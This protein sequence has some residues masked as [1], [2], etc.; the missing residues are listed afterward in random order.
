MER[1]QI[2]N[3][4]CGTSC[5]PEEHAVC[6]N[7][8]YAKCSAAVECFIKTLSDQQVAYVTA[9]ISEDIYLKAC[10]G[11]GKTEVIGIKTAYEVKRWQ[12]KNNGIAVL[13]FTNSAEKEL[14]NRI[15]SFLQKD[16]GYPHY[17]GTFTSWL[18][19]Y[20]ANP[21]MSTLTKYKGVDGKDKSIRI[22]DSKCTSDFLNAFLTQYTYDSLGKLPANHYYFDTEH[23]G[24]II[25]VGP[26]R[27]G[28]QIL[29]SFCERG[30]WVKKDL[31]KVKK[32]FWETG[33]ATYEDVEQLACRLLE[34]K[35]EITKLIAKRFPVII[36]DE[37]QDLSYV[38]LEILR[39]LHEQGSKIHLVGDLDQAI[40][41]FR[42]IA[43]HKTAEFISGVG[44]REQ[45][46]TNNY[47]SVD[48]IV[49]ATGA[50]LCK[51]KGYATG[52]VP[53]K[54]D[55]PLRA[56]LYKKGQEPK[57]LAKFEEALQDIGLS[58]DESRIIVRNN[59]LREKLY[60]RNAP[61][62]T[63][64]TIE[65][66]ANFLLMR[67]NDNVDDFQLATR[68][69]ARAIQRCF[70][71]TQQ[72]SSFE[73]LSRPETIDS[74]E[75]RKLIIAIQ[76]KMITTE[77]L[78]NLEL[79]WGEWKTEL[80]NTFTSAYL[81]SVPGLEHL[82]PDFGKLRKKVKDTPVCSSFQAT[83]ALPLCKIETIHGC[84]GMSLDAVLFMSAYQKNNAETG[85]YWTDWFA[86]DL[87]NLE[88]NHRLAYV[89]FSRA[90]YLLMLGIPNPPSSPISDEQKEQ[91]ESIGFILECIE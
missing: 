13:T 34:T 33:F 38:Q 24:T 52:N 21:F 77:K 47:R 56:V 60:G 19:G 80:I 32:R 54:T 44:M 64:N 27:N 37:C 79:T 85:A 67:K 18:L 40:Y 39:F 68:V 86:K 88:E 36:V 9:P 69:L 30:D 70:F 42:R 74:G 15:E 23:K 11:S 28:Q 58:L 31:A 26:N 20:I 75:W 17:V 76:N 78:Q 49:C 1:L 46:L 65:D 35:N 59:S 43:P 8:T 48:S 81:N 10:P 4:L 51:P 84:K 7:V 5:L 41:E 3:C 6:Q 89:A 12:H 91:L 63:V 71:K 14:A 83:E 87:A 2:A 57:V 62:Q 22:V 66:F 50:T 16:M 25:Y 45:Q 73:Q 72:H 53:C 90:R 82:A 61:N 29:D 55:K